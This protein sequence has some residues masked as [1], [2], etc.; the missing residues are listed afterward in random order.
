MLKYRLSFVTLILGCLILSP[1]LFPVSANANEYANGPAKPADGQIYDIVIYGGTSS[2]VAAA[3]EAK[4]H[5]KSIIVVCPDKHLGGLSSGGLGFTD[6]GNTA[7]VGGLAREF[8][9]R[10]YLEYQKPENWNW[11]RVDEFANVGQGTRAMKHDDQTMWIFEPHIAERVFDAWIEEFQIP[12]VRN[13]K[14][15]RE[16]GV[17]VKD[18]RIESIQTLDG[19]VYC[20]QMFI[21]ATYE[22]DLMAAAGV[23]YTVG[24]EANSQYGEQWNGNQVGVLHHGHWFK[25]KI[26][27]YNVPGDPASGKLK[28]VDDSVPGEYGEADDRI[29]AYCYRL[30][31]T[32][33][34]ENRIPFPKP[35]NYNPQDY[36]LLRRVL[37]SGWR[38]AFHKFDMVPNRK[39]D[40][41]NHGPFSSDFIGMNYDYPDAS[42]ERRAEIL[43]EHENY[44]KG[45]FY[46]LANDPSVPEDVRTKMSSWGLAKDEFPETGGWPH[47]IYVREA[48]RM[49]GS[50][51]VTENDCFRRPTV[52]AA[53]VSVGAVGMGSYTLDSHNVRRYVTP[54]GYVQNE[55]DIGVHPKQPYAIDYNALVPKRGQCANLLVSVCVSS[56]HIAFGSIRMEPVFMILGQSSAAAACFAIDDNVC[57]QDVSYAKL[58]ELL[59]SEGQILEYTRGAG[60]QTNAGVKPESLEGIVVDDVQ[61]VKTGDWTSGDLI[62]FVGSDYLHDGNTGLAPDGKKSI[63]FSA[64][65]PAKGRYEIRISYCPSSNRATNALVVVETAHGPVET[66]INQKLTPPIN[67]LFLPLGEYEFDKAAV[68]TISNDQ[69]DGYVIAD[70]IQVIQKKDSSR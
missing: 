33:C 4:K 35:E 23:E 24:R 18:G 66:R 42:Y 28:Y 22:G 55:G 21:D 5:G 59:K 3:V 19:T 31:M 13:A 34:D 53:G 36:E 48:R 54:E 16:S 61:A 64:P 38:E 6:S 14:L 51:V 17:S 15:N 49:V 63:R 29:Q 9:H 27:P 56:S 52:P 40:T 62:P 67:K 11:Q 12:V 68:V 65:L 30:C 58:A 26:S 2:A 37:E 47:Q 20:G 69:A 7:T 1:F 70:A 39:T 32:D 10:I 25:A 45:L 8:Y 46:F 50:Y 43:K 44:Q 41:N 60:R 57:V